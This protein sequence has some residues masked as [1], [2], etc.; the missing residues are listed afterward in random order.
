MSYK[1]SA[2]NKKYNQGGVSDLRQK[3]YIIIFEADTPAGKLFDVTLIVSIIL[4]VIAVMLDSVS[5]I[6]EA[7]GNVLYA[8]EWFFTVLFT[9]EYILRLYCI[10]RPLRYAGSFFGIVDIAVVSCKS[11]A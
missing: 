9:I 10:G 4:S 1:K 11:S 5:S 2:L 8:I 3:L 7:Y 6:N